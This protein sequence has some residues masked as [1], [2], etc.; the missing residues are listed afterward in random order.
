MGPASYNG[1]FGLRPSHGKIDSDGVFI[2]LEPEDTVGPFSHH[3]NDLVLSY[4]IMADNLTIYDNFM[5]KD[6][7]K[8]KDIRIGFV[9]N[10]NDGFTLNFDEGSFIYKLDDEVSK[11]FDNT[12]KNLRKLKIDVIEFEIPQVLFNEMFEEIKEMSYPRYNNCALKC[13]KSNFDNY[14]GNS[15]RFQHDTSYKSGE[16]INQSPLLKSD[17]K[18]ILS[19]NNYTSNECKS[20]CQEYINVKNKLSKRIDSWYQNVTVSPPI[21]LL[22]FPTMSRIP[23]ELNNSNAENYVSATFLAPLS[24]YASLSIPASFSSIQ[25]N[26]PDGLPIGMM[27]LGPE[28]SLLKIFKAASLYEE[29]F[30]IRKSAPKSVPLISKKCNNSNTITSTSSLNSLFIMIIL[31]ILTQ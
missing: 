7:L 30:L 31:I 11:A 3:L 6:L 21:D 26:A 2:I 16:D 9:K 4:S 23:H 27:L 1:I 8:P 22:L 10:F 12:V 15:N 28:E 24:G 17:F 5:N 18:I 13:L 14:L 19:E 20:Y 29:S 25:K